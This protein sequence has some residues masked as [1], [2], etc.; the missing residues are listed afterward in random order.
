MDR[1]VERKVIAA[2][3]GATAG[4]IV[5]EFAL[6]LADEIWWPG[7]EAVVPLPVAAFVNLVVIAGL[8]WI[9]GYLARHNTDELAVYPKDDLVDADGE[10]PV[11]IH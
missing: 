3:G 11:P 9:T 7:D 1:P 8:T 5:S 4:T 10:G 2:T 6:Y